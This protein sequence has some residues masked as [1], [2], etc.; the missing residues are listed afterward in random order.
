MRKFLVSS[1]EL[2]LLT[3]W[4]SNNFFTVWKLRL[5]APVLCLVISEGWKITQFVK[6][7][8]VRVFSQSN[9]RIIDS[10]QLFL[11]PLRKKKLVGTGIGLWGFTAKR[12][13]VKALPAE[14]MLLYP[15]RCSL[16]ARKN[17]WP[18]WALARKLLS[19]TSVARIVKLLFSESNRRSVASVISRKVP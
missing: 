14:T 1:K 5:Q 7:H 18:H 2:Y 4:Q 19:G 15:S 10:R 13:F 8:S 12:E 16:E 17:H 9:N 6:P 11:S 3:I